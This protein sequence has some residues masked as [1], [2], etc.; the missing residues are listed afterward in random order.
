MMTWAALAVALVNLLAAIYDQRTATKPQRDMASR[1]KELQDD[2]DRTN[3]AIVDGDARQLAEQF[4]RE[5]LESAKRLIGSNGRLG[6]VR[7]LDGDADR[8]EPHS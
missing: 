7:L 2:V 6:T 5:R 8:D 3:Q 1:E 4:E